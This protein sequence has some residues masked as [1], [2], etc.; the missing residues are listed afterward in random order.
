VVP[1][2]LNK[3]VV[4]GIGFVPRRLLLPIVAGRQRRK[5]R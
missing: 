3:L 5:G 1:G 2:V 4:Y